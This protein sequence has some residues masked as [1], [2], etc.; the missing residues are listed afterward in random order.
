MGNK[1]YQIHD[2]HTFDSYFTVKFFDSTTIV[3]AYV[4]VGIS[5]HLLNPQREMLYID[6]CYIVIQETTYLKVNNNVIIGRYNNNIPT[7]YLGGTDL[8][9]SKFNGEIEI[10]SKTGFMYIFNDT[11]MSRYFASW[12][13]IDTPN[14]KKNIDADTFLFGED[15]PDDIF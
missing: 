3:F 12:I 14:F 9:S 2:L 7:V 4:N 13:P 5:E 1:V 10:Q 8:K 6:R 11:K 15:L